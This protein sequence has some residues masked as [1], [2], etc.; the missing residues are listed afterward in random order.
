MFGKTATNGAASKPSGMDMMI[1]SL[2]NGMGVS[3]D[4]LVTY[5]EQGKQLATQF[6]VAMQNT[7][8]RLDLIEAEQRA[9]RA[10]LES[11]IALKQEN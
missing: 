10:L 7:S 4:A 8:T 3:P 1:K 2:L 11:A 5:I 6:V 9:Q